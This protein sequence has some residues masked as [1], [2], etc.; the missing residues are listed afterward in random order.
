MTVSGYG[1]LPLWGSLLFCGSRWF[2]E[3]VCLSDVHKETAPERGFFVGSLQQVHG[4]QGPE[5]DQRGTDP[6]DADTAQ[7]ELGLFEQS[8]AVRDG[9]RRGG[10]RQEEGTRC[11]EADDQRQDERVGVTRECR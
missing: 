1:V 3:K 6:A 8:G 10:N 5:D 4:K 11:R 7:A 2:R 9:V